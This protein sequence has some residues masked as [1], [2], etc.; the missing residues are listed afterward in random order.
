MRS[1]NIEPEAI[2]GHTLIGVSSSWHEFEGRRSA[3]PV[4]LW[5]SF[6]GL[7]TLRLHSLN[8][9][10]ITS[11]DVYDPDDM[12]EHG[13]ILVEQSGPTSLVERVG[14]HVERVSRLD[15]A[16][17]GASVGIVLH[18]PGGSVG[19]ADLGDDLV[20]TTWPADSW[21]REGVSVASTD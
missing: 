4:H 6:D 11:D 16:P 17:P 14:E 9:L 15:Q 18:F 2:V 21:A 1:V 3:E 5:L 10:M 13:R 20:V 8:G 7:G 12:G 19:I